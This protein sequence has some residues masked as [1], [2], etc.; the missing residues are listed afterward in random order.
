MTPSVS[1][2]GATVY[3]KFGRLGE[4]DTELV[5][6]GQRPERVDFFPS[7][8]GADELAAYI[9]EKIAGGTS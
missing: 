6:D 9:A 3:F 7:P 4:L 8:A 2:Q 5:L 1:V